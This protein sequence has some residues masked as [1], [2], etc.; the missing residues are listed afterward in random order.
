[1]PGVHEIDC[2]RVALEGYPGFVLRPIA[3]RQSYKADDPRR[4]TIERMRIRER[5]MTSLAEGTHALRLRVVAPA[6]IRDAAIHDASGDTLDALACLAQA[7]WGAQRAAQRYGLPQT[8]D[9]LE[10]WIAGA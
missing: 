9:A 1:M 3:G 6:A 10:G 7:A 5:L 4:H 8:I 2:D